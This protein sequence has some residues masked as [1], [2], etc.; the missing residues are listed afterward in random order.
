MR[1]RLLLNM[2]KQNY[3]RHDSKDYI[4]TETQAFKLLFYVAVTLGIIWNLLYYGFVV[5]ALPDFDVDDERV[6]DKLNEIDCFEKFVQELEDI[7]KE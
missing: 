3:L 7:V 1:M 6:Y 5:H 4:E 2:V